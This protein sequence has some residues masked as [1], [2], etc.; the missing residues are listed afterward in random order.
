M[1]LVLG[2]LLR[3]V[4]GH[5]QGAVPTDPPWGTNVPEIISSINPDK[6]LGKTTRVNGT[7]KSILEITQWAESIPSTKL[8]R[9]P[10]TATTL[11]IG[12]T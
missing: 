2:K 11:R 6:T 12:L 10:R 7:S 3:K 5:V 8:P 9:T 4:C 1:H